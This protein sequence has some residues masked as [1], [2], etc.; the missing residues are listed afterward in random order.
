MLVVILVSVLLLLSIV[1]DFS[2]MFSPSV[3]LFILLLVVSLIFAVLLLEHF[4]I[5]VR[6]FIICAFS[7]SF[8]L[9][10]VSLLLIL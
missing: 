5:T 4:C 9:G 6:L 2:V 10:S 1:L 3:R 8:A 7:L